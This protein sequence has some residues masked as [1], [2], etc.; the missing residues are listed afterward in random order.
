MPSILDAQ[1]RALA[2]QIPG[3]APTSVTYDAQGRL[4]T[5]V[6][7][8]G[9]TARTS[10]FTYNPQGFLATLTDPLSRGVQ[11]TYDLA[12]RVLTQT[13]PDGRVI[14]TSYD[15]NGN[16]A[17]ITPPSRPAHTFDYTPVDL[18]A[19]YTPPDLGIGTGTCQQE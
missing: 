19:S 10:T 5:V 16:V 8:T 6:Q 13:L 18:E 1:G 3:L 14:Q 4:T 12:G 11:F 17:S 2:Q 15:A 7:G 9:G